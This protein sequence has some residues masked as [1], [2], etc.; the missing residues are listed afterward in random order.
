MLGS[1]L[2]PMKMTCKSYVYYA[3]FLFHMCVLTKALDNVKM[4]EVSVIAS[5]LKFIISTE[6]CRSRFS[7]MAPGRNQCPQKGF[8]IPQQVIKVIEKGTH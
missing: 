1:F 7:S 5:F 8:L 6:I 4:S 2:S 3:V